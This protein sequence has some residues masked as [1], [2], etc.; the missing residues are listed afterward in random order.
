MR[1]ATHAHPRSI[2]TSAINYERAWLY[3]SVLSAG[4]YTLR[5]DAGRQHTHIPAL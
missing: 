5:Q 2:V 3:P 1:E 4:S